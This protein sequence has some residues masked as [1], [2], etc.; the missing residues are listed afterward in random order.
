M[1]TEMTSMELTMWGEFFVVANEKQEKA[2][3]DAETERRIMG[4]G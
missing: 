3:R 1:L 4:D 2:Q